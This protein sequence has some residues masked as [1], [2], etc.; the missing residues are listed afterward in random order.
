MIGPG[1][2]L[3]PFRGFLQDLRAQKSKGKEIGDVHLFFGC[4]KSKL[5]FL[6]GVDGCNNLCLKSQPL[7][8]S[9]PV[10]CPVFTRRS[11]IDK[12][13]QPLSSLPAA[14]VLTSQA[15]CVSV[16]L[17][18]L[19]M[20]LLNSPCLVST[21]YRCCCPPLPFS[22]G[23]RYESEIRGFVADKTLTQLHT[24][25]S[26]D[27]E[28]KVRGRT[29]DVAVLW[30][31]GWRATPLGPNNCGLRM[32]EFAMS[33]GH[34]FVWLSW[35]LGKTELPPLHIRTHARKVARS[36][37]LHAVAPF[38]NYSVRTLTLPFHQIYVQ[39]RLR[40]EAATVWALLE[41]SAHIYVCGDGTKMSRDVHA[42]L[43]AMAKEL[44]GKTEQQAVAYLKNLQQLRRYQQV[45]GATYV[46]MCMCVWRC[47]ARARMGLGVQGCLAD[48]VFDDGHL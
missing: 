5:H 40:E 9:P 24:A 15:A 25:F 17:L 21:A 26:R 7:P 12:V 27:Q 28:E 8:C 6:Y 14:V 33:S 35:Q 20:L 16:A 3:A 44:G 42:E 4:Q 41:K 48:L 47:Y 19:L 1:T 2:G 10:I 34:G 37:P 30:F 43:L 23:H 46:R 29:R 11:T 22:T 18:M 13:P 38:F 39:H 31:M 36:L 45:R 32:D